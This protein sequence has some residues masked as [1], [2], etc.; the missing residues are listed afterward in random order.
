MSI[1]KY[2]LGTIVGAALLGLAKSKLG[3]RNETDPHIVLLGR[4]T[5]GDKILIDNV[6]EDIKGIMEVDDNERQIFKFPST[7][8][9]SFRLEATNVDFPESPE[10]E[11]DEYTEDLKR[12][13]F[14]E[15]EYLEDDDENKQDWEDWT[16]VPDLYVE[17]FVEQK[18]NELMETWREDCY[19]I[20]YRFTCR[21]VE[22]LR[23]EIE[24]SEESFQ[25]CKRFID[26]RNVYLHISDYDSEYDE[27][28]GW[29]AVELNIFINSKNPL[30]AVNFMQDL[31]QFLEQTDEYGEFDNVDIYQKPGVKK[32]DYK[33]ET[34][35]PKLRKR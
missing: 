9:I 23:H 20:A 27:D 5:V 26:S 6:P 22:T 25:R 3:G 18:R 8:I 31:T 13:Y 32:M 30:F 33:K 19:G 2:T 24:H 14:D 34:I 15:N 10:E 4:G 1:S 17:E 12:D 21:V 7:A 28:D 29:I 16:D 35:G 11:I